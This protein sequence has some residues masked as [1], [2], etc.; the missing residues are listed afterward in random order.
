VNNAVAVVVVGERDGAGVI[1]LMDGRAS[2]RGG[3]V[4][5]GGRAAARYAGRRGRAAVSFIL[6]E[7]WISDG[8][9]ACPG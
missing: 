3:V 1:V 5:C 2:P 7:G 8:E 6:G 9:L 4:P